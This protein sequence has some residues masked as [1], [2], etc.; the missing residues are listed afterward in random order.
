MCSKGDKENPIYN[1]LV[2]CLNDLK[3]CLAVENA[4]FF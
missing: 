1:D 2:K 3:E 4:L